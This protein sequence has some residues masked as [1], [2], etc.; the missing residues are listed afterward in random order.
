MTTLDAAYGT[1]KVLL[2]ED[3]EGSR[4]IARHL[5]ERLGIVTIVEAADGGSGF[6]EA[7]RT[8]PDVVLCDMHMQPVNGQQFLVRVRDSSIAWLRTLP[9]IFLSSDNSLDTLRRATQRHVD[10]FM[11]KPVDRDELKKQLDLVITRR[12]VAIP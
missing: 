4:R 2:I 6:D 1:L 11:V 5:L 8:H 3:D 9:V 10:G 7:L 12:G